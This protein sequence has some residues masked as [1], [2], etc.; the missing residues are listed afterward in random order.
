MP[1][2]VVHNVYKGASLE[3]ILVVH[4]H[5]GVLVVVISLEAEN[6]DHDSFAFP[7]LIKTIH[8]VNF[9]TASTSSDNLQLI[10]DG[11]EAKRQTGASCQIHSIFGFAINAPFIGKSLLAIYSSVLI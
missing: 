7:I 2:Q 4:H 1:G 6:A 3:L 5:H 10:A 9:S 8:L 11:A